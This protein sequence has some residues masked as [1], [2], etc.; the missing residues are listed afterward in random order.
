MMKKIVKLC[1]LGLFAYALLLSACT[2]VYTDP[3]VGGSIP[4]MSGGTHNSTSKPTELS[5]NASYGEA[6]SKLDEI[7]TYCER[8]SS[9]TNNAVRTSAQTLK[10]ELDSYSSYWSYMSSQM[11]ISINGLIGQLV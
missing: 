4:E 1:A 11:I 8:N 7:I 5:S 3:D 10:N 6:V 9:P 2:G